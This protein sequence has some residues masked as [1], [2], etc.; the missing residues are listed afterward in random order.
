MHIVCADLKSVFRVESEIAQTP[1]YNFT[2]WCWHTGRWSINSI[3]GWLFFPTCF[4]LAGRCF[5][6]SFTASPALICPSFAHH[7][8][9]YITFSYHIFFPLLS[10]CLSSLDL[11]LFLPF[12]RSPLHFATP[13]CPCPYLP[14]SV[15]LSFSFSLAPFLLCIES[16]QANVEWHCEETGVFLHHWRHQQL[17]HAQQR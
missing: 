4:S 6:F 16:Y 13:P 1:T 15:S 11:F 2:Y 3:D 8:P 17:R 5:A 14:T 7:N 10:S 9:I 12:I